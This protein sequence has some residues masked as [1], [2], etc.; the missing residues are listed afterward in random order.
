[1][2]ATFVASVVGLSMELFVTRLAVHFDASPLHP[3]GINS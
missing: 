1:M 2:W 3:V